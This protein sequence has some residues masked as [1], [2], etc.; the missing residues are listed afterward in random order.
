MTMWLRNYAYRVEIAFELIAMAIVSLV[1]LFLLT[2][3][4]HTVRSSLTNPAAILKD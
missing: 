4:Y 3:T 2:I 1:V